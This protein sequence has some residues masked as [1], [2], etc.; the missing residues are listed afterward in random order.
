MPHTTL[1]TLPPA[2]LP[3]PPTGT[4]GT[5]GALLQHAALTRGS[6][7][8]YIEHGHHWTWDAV[9]SNSTRLAAGLLGLGLRRG[10]RIGIIG[11]NQIEW[12]LLFYAAT[13]VG[14]AVV[15]L[16]VRYRDNELLAMLADS[17]TRAVFTLVQHEGFDFI[18]MLGRLRPQLPA[19]QQMIT[20]DGSG[21]GSLAALMDSTP[22]NPPAAAA[23]HMAGLHAA[24]Q[25]VQ[26]GDVAMVIYT[27]GTT[28]RPKGAGLT[29]ASLLASASAQAAHTR[30]VPGDVLHAA[31][32]LNHVGGITCGALT[33]L[34]GGGTVVLVAEF[35]ADTVLRLMQQQAPTIVAGV[36]TMLTLLLMNPRVDSVDFSRVR[37]V[38]SGGS[39]VDPVLLERLAIRMPNAKL[40][41]LYGL[42]ESSGAL[43]M[44]P[45]HCSADDTLHSIGL[46]FADVRLR[47]ADADGQA[48][49]AGQVGELCF[50]GGGVVPGYIGAAGTGFSADGWLQTGDLGA[51]DGRGMITLKGRKKDM[52]IQ[53]GFN[54]YPAEVEALVNR[55]PKVVMAAGIGAPDAVLGE[56]GR[57]YVIPQPGSGLTEAELRAWCS[58]HLADYKVPRQWVLRDA[59]PMTPAGKIHKAALRDELAGM[60]P[61]GSTGLK[62]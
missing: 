2:L 52:Y 60:A 61:L 49:P 26:P 29:H 33:M 17:Q 5:L 28:G 46:P 43:V 20:L 13:Q 14:V 11:L 12:L 16:S 56:V 47:I 45:W 44:T 25:A 22:A 23:A 42:T 53:G 9:H 18:S 38:F 55:H 6:S 1:P 54:V 40:M 48:L 34:V 31:N 51:V 37:L 50:Q 24:R 27:S 15:G 8:A 30:V 35:K 57:L 7:T 10:D 3:T 19:L 4:L 32:P 36:P 41:N 21:P 62:R 59:L 39:N 58:Q